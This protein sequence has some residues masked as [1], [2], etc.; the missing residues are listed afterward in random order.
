MLP[1]TAS[2]PLP[3]F[4]FGVELSLRQTPNQASPPSTLQPSNPMVEDPLRCMHYRSFQF[5][6]QYDSTTGWRLSTGVSSWCAA[7]AS[8]P[9]PLPSGF[10]LGWGF[11]LAAL[12]FALGFGFQKN[13]WAM[14][15]ERSRVAKCLVHPCRKH[16]AGEKTAAWRN[17]LRKVVEVSGPS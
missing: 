15:G 9:S 8:F 10:A 12:Q 4:V 13:S 11:H 14:E 7:C 5:D 6:G 17:V 2:Y 16:I 3:F 1:L